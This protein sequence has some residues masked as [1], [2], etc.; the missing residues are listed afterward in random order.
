MAGSALMAFLL[1]LF[2]A[3]PPLGAQVLEFDTELVERDLSGGPFPIPLAS[4]PLNVLP[5]SIEGYGFVNS[6]VTITLSSQR[7][8]PS[9]SA[10]LG[11][12]VCLPGNW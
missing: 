4:D 7:V 3:A 10:V 11:K 12:G 2:I 6:D 5:D 8:V 1:S 9:R